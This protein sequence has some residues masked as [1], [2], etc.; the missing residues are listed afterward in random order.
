MH[1]SALF[2]AHPGQRA[3]P[4]QSSQATHPSSGRL[5]RDMPHPPRIRLP[6]HLTRVSWASHC[7]HGPAVRTF[8]PRGAMEVIEGTGRSRLTEAGIK[9]EGE[10]S[11][12]VRV[13]YEARKGQRAFGGNGDATYLGDLTH[14][15]ESC[16]AGGAGGS[17]LVRVGVSLQHS[18]TLRLDS[19][20]PTP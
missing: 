3:S 20:R 8:L 6:R 5:D 7:R 18:S 10:G 19:R 2:N 4:A 9:R 11:S 12:G 17:G 1:G 13:S 15:V 14:V 16:H